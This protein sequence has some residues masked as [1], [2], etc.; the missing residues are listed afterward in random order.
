M[1]DKQAMSIE[2]G[3]FYVM[4]KLNGGITTNQI[5]DA[6]NHQRQLLRKDCQPV[7]G[8]QVYAIICRFP[9]LFTK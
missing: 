2:E 7:T 6:I 9:K 8:K 1:A 5:A 4:V 3:T